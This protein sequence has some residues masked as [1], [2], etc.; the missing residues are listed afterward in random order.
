[1]KARTV[2]IIDDQPEEA[3]PLIQHLKYEGY[4]VLFADSAQSGLE[5]ARKERPDVIIC[6]L[7]MPGLG[8]YEVLEAIAG[9]PEMRDWP[10]L[11]ADSNWTIENWSRQR[12]GRTAD[13]HVNKP[14]NVREVACF[15]ERIDV[16][17]RLT[18]EATE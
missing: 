12:N 5:I 13:C 11:L 2:L 4:G 17:V 16:A 10:F 14:Y 8:G 1:M 3:E 6:D 7:E 18:P 15:L 9:D